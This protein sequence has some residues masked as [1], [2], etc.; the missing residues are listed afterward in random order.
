MIDKMNWI[1]RI[2]CGTGNCYLLRENDNA[3]LVDTCQTKYLS[4]ILEAC[5]GVNVRL[6][7]LTHGHFDHIQ[8]AAA[9][10]EALQA[11]IAMHEADLPFISDL[12]AEP[13]DAERPMGKLLLSLIRSGKGTPALAPFEPT[14]FLRDGDSLSDYGVEA[15]IIGLP[16]HTKGSIGILAWG[17]VLLVG[18]AMMNFMTPSE[19]LI[20]SDYNQMQRSLSIIGSVCPEAVY[21]GHGK[22]LRTGAFGERTI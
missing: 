7:V 15:K 18:D 2:K 19:S 17:T 1:E 5:R 14:L 4:K 6:I 13:L 9:L 21:F 8:N 11:P 22:P 3:V 16:G 20:Y 12:C 10:S